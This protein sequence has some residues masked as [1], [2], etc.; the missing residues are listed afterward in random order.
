MA[1]T[2][3]SS[4]TSRTGA[5]DDGFSAAERGA[6]K[7]RAKE[8]K[9]AARPGSGG[10]K[11]AADQ[12]AVL[13]KIA[14]M[15]E[16]DRAIAERLHAVITDAAPDLLP[17]LWY[18]MPGYAKDGKVLVFFQSAAKFETRY[19]TLGF[20]DNAQLDDGTIWPT[21]YA[22]TDLSAADE[23]RIADLIRKAVR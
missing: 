4:G 6:I 16:A 14:E 10:K 7:D 21:A 12:A 2:K 19:S 8:L 18:G 22:I 23:D 1:D 3:R 15:Q 11:A 13:Q 20:N 5:T 9:A 17:K